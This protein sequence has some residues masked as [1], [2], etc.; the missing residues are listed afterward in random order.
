PAITIDYFLEDNKIEIV[1]FVKI[2][3]EGAELDVL[4]GAIKSMTLKKIKFLQVEYGGTYLDAGIKFTD[5]IKFVHSV[6]Y[7][8][9]EKTD[10]WKEVT[11]D[12][13]IEDYRYQNFLLT[14]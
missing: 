9:F 7:K 12:N 10:T 4:N 3:V 8:V 1:D 6:G 14:Y 11:L 5:V 2:D 13:F